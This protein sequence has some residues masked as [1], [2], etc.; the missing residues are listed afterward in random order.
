MPTKQDDED[1]DREEFEAM[2]EAE[3]L[4]QR[5]LDYQEAMAQAWAM[6]NDD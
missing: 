3:E 1:R 5:E 2:L 4:R 6:E